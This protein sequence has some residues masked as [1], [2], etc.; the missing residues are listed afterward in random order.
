M[1]ITQEQLDA[2]NSPLRKKRIKLELLD[3][4]LKVLDALE[5]YAIDGSINVDANSSMRRS[6]S[7]T[8]AIP[9]NK[10]SND[11]LDSI[12]GLEISVEGKVWIDKYIKLYVGLDKTS[13]SSTNT[14]W[15]KL[16]VFLIDK[17]I[18]N[19]S[20]TSYQIS[21]NCIDRMAELTGDRQGQLTGFGTKILKGD[22][23]GGDSFNYQSYFENSKTPLQVDV[24]ERN[25]GNLIAFTYSSSPYLQIGSL[26]KESITSVLFPSNINTEILDFKW[27]P[28]MEG[29]PVLFAYSTE[30]GT[31]LY[32]YNNDVIYRTITTNFSGWDF[33]FSSDGSKLLFGDESGSSYEYVFATQTLSRVGDGISPKFTPDENY[34][35]TSYSLVFGSSSGFRAYDASTFADVTSSVFPSQVTSWTF[36]E[37]YTFDAN[38]KHLFAQSVAANILGEVKPNNICLDI[39]SYPFKIL[40]AI[41]NFSGGGSVKYYNNGKRL[42]VEKD[43]TLTNEQSFDIYDTATSPYKRLPISLAIHTVYNGNAGF[44]CLGFDIVNNIDSLVLIGNGQIQNGSIMAYAHTLLYSIESDTQIYEN[45]KTYD[46]LKA[47]IDDL[48]VIK[49]YTIADIPKDYEYLPFDISV[50]TSAT[51]YDILQKFKEILSTWEFY[52]DVDGVFRIEPLITGEKAPTYPISLTTYISDEMAYDF[53]NV[54]NQVVVYGKANNCTYYTEDVSYSNGTLNLKYESLIDENNLTVKGTTFGFLTPKSLN[55]NNLTEINID[56]GQAWQSA[57]AS[58]NFTTKSYYI[59]NAWYYT[60]AQDANIGGVYRSANGINWTKI[61]TRGTTDIAFGNGILV[62]ATQNG[63]YWKDDLD[64]WT[65]ATG[66]GTSYFNCIM[67]ANN[68]FVAGSNTTGLYYSSDGKNWTQSNFNSNPARAVNY[69]EYE[70]NYVTKYRWVASTANGIFYSDDGQSW[71]LSYG[72]SVSISYQPRAFVWYYTSGNTSIKMSC[73][74]AYHYYSTDGGVHWYTISP[75]DYYIYDWAFLQNALKIV[76]IDAASCYISGTNLE[77]YPGLIPVGISHFCKRDDDTILGYGYGGV[78]STMDG[79]S[80]KKILSTSSTVESIVVHNKSICVVCV[81]K[82][83][84]LEDYTKEYSL[85]GELVSFEGA[86]DNVPQNSLQPNEV[87]IVRILDNLASTGD[88]YNANA[89]PIFELYSRQQPSACLVDDNIESPFYINN[90]LKGIT[91]YAGTAETSSGYDFGTEYRLT[92]NNKSAIGSLADGTKITFMANFSNAYANGETATKITVCASDGSVLKSALPLVTENNHN[93]A[94]AENKLSRDYT[95]YLIE[96]DATDNVFVYKGIS[97]ATYT[98]VLSGGEFDNIHAD[99]L[100]YERC[101]WE[102]YSHSNL[103]D[104]I[105]LGIVPNYGLDVNYRINYQDEDYQPFYVKEGPVHQ[106]FATVDDKDFYVK[107]DAQSQFFLVKKISF[108]LGLE[109]TSQ[110]VSAI[111]IYDSGNLLGD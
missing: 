91:F 110:V 27:A 37:N 11:F 103:Q 66:S 80:W 54:K 24:L 19:I 75:N 30:N 36:I 33:C 74:L 99:Q 28:I 101:L 98:L 4:D 18:K 47:V 10:S 86:V 84:F 53:N 67:Y 89:Q 14:V 73:L 56:S 70:D 5:G 109:T 26:S 96:Y 78:Y 8:M 41:P 61:S 31:F 38:I 43:R 46:A 51:V 63:I 64:N 81:D 45:T 59:N 69:I 60:V 52:F 42:L 88:V 71:T 95:I 17:P 34:I 72:V 65:L 62:A 40:D 94:V 49:K 29:V 93:V 102:L 77:F 25:A 105:S 32:D 50:G 23:V 108:S 15:Y 22:Y 58:S 12:D 7:V 21:F 92:L 90:G 1:K 9:N 82:V 20:A 104:S 35:I 39:S 68:L 87:Y 44:Y 57:S 6:G 79:L 106:P 2:L 85:S 76:S 97:P 13:K 111:R 55:A 100:A 83:Y 3:R 48:T 16:G 107:M